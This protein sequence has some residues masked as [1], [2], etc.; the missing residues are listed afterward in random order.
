MNWARIFPNGD[1]EVS[2]EEGLKFYHEVFDECKKYGIEPLVTL[3]HYKTPLHLV[4]KYGGWI[5]RDLIKF[6][7]NYCR[8]VFNRYKGKVKYYL[9]INE[10]NMM[11]FG[12]YMAGG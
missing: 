7:E 6:F 11:E 10:I 3:S 4:N 9:T 2:N 12:S 5:S 1:D 8:T